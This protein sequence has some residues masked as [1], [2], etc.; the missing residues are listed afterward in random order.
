MD[1]IRI[2]ISEEEVCKRIKEIGEMISEKYKGEEVHL[3]RQDV[4]YD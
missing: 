2:L 4:Y 1:N 3:E